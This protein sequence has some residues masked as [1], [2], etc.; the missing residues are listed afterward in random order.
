MRRLVR[1]L[2]VLTMLVASIGLASTQAT[3]SAAMPC[4]SWCFNICDRCEFDPSYCT[5]CTNCLNAC[6]GSC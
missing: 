5:R 2:L 4:C 3:R 6:N 1:K